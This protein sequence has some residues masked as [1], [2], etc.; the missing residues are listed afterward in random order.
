MRA[1]TFDTFCVFMCFFHLG[2]KIQFGEMWRDSHSRLFFFQNKI[3]LSVNILYMLCYTSYAICYTLHITYC[4]YFQ[5]T[6]MKYFDRSLLFRFVNSKKQR[7]FH[8]NKLENGFAHFNTI[9]IFVTLPH[10][11]PYQYPRITLLMCF[12]L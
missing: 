9:M 7:T 10:P 5:R 8:M 12:P 2:V 3:K 4:L 6:T 11:N 1:F